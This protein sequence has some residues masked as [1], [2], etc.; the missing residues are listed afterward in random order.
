MKVFLIVAISVDGFIAQDADQISTA[1][2]SPEDKQFF[3][4]R[5][6]QAGVI[7]MGRKTFETIGRPLPGRINIV[8]SRQT[9]VV[10]EVQGSRFKIQEFDDSKIKTPHSAKATWGKQ[11]SKVDDVIFTTSLAPVE[12]INRLEQ[13]GFS[14]V[15]ICGG[16]QIYTQFLEAGVVDTLYVTIEPVIFGSGIKLVDKLSVGQLISCRLKE[17]KKLNER[18]TVL[19]EYEIKED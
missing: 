16:Q 5:T 10:S 13:A 18:G 2:T 11:S 15:A 1:W 6:K 12:L 7:V 19:L 4:E 14:E 9:L 3:R 17:I 8:L